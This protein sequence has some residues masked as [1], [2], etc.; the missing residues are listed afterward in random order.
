[1]QVVK[2]YF[3]KRS[4]YADTGMK[5]VPLQE[6]LCQCKVSVAQGKFARMLSRKCQSQKQSMNPGP[7]PAFL[8]VQI[9]KNYFT[10][11][12]LMSYFLPLISFLKF[13]LKQADD[14]T[15]VILWAD[16]IWRC[17]GIS[18]SILRAHH[19]IYLTPICL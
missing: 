10:A 14:K 4:I 2:K 1:M 6:H 18:E 5:S 3:R 9:Q 8:P 16:S 12:S 7:F 11:L 19:N 17:R 15:P 13:L